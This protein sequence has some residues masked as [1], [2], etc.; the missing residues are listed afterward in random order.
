MRW[1]VICG[2]LLMAAAAAEAE[3]VVRLKNGRSIRGEVIEQDSKSLRFRTAS[4][5]TTELNAEDIADIGP[6]AE[7]AGP[8]APANQPRPAAAPEGPKHSDDCPENCRRCEQMFRHSLDGLCAKVLVRPQLTPV[9]V[10]LDTWPALQVPAS[11][12]LGIVLLGEG[13]VGRPGLHQRTVLQLTRFVSTWA[14]RDHPHLQAHR[15]WA[16]A[17]GTLFLAELHRTAPSASLRR[18]IQRLVRLLESSR[19]GSEGWCHQFERSGYGPFIGVTIWCAAALGA[20]KQQGI[21]VDEDGLAEAF[22]ALRK[23]IGQTGGASYYADQPSLVSVGRT[24]GVLWVLR[25]YAGLDSAETR[26]AEGFL[27]RHLDDAPNGHASPLMNFGWSALGAGAAGPKTNRRFWLV[28]RDTVLQA[29]H[30]SGS[31]GVQPWKDIGFSAFNE[32]RGPFEAKG[33]TWPDRMYGDGWATVWMLLTWQAGRG[34]CV[35]TAST[36]GPPASGKGAPA[37]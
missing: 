7:A 23:S 3:V 31:F 10:K 24:G 21:D 15:T 18:K 14:E 11:S 33:T 4:G 34:R 16:V 5:I 9:P 20:A 6:A 8:R 25:H 26:R 29:R 27:A 36:D 12:V 17:F 2:G 19:Q 22:A 32:A 35:L 1:V 28:H 13:E 37:R 30:V